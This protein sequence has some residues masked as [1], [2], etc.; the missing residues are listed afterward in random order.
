MFVV[1]VWNGCYLNIFP[2]SITARD[3][4]FQ[5]ASGSDRVRLYDRGLL[6]IGSKN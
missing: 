3:N 5:S 2:P 1:C 4:I 6:E